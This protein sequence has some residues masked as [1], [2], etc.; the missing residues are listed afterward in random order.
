MRNRPVVSKKSRG[1]RKARGFSRGELRK[2]GLSLKQAAGVGLLVDV[3]RRTVHDENVGLIKQQQTKSEVKAK[4]TS[5]R[6]Q[7]RSS[8]G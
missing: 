1:R 2:A 4:K 6:R 5:R 8:T 7:A 3:R